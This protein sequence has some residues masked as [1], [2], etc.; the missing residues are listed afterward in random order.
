[1]PQSTWSTDVPQAFRRRYGRTEEEFHQMKKTLPPKKIV[2]AAKAPAPLAKKPAP[3][4]APAPLA[5]KPA[6]APAPVAKKPAPAPAPLAKKAA[7][8]PAPLA[9]KPAPAPAPL[10]K[11]AAPAPAPLAK[12]VAPAPAPLAKKAAPAPVA[13]KGAPAPLAKKVVAKAPVAA[14]KKG[15]PAK[16]SSGPSIRLGKPQSA[17]K[18]IVSG[19]R[20]T[21]EAFNRLFHE[22]LMAMYKSVEAAQIAKGEDPDISPTLQQSG[23]IVKLVE[24]VWAAAT[25][26]SSIAWAGLMVKRKYI[27]P[28]VFSSPIMKE[29]HSFVPGHYRIKV[30]HPCYPTA[31]KEATQKGVNDSPEEGWFTPAEWD[32]DGNCAATDEP[33]NVA[34]IIS[35]EKAKAKADAKA[36][37]KA[38]KVAKAT[39]AAATADDEEEAAAEEEDEV[40]EEVAEDEEATEEAGE[41]EA[42]E[43][44][45]EEAAEEEEEAAEDEEEAAEEEEEEA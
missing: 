37:A 42:T 19:G 9:K 32:E 4:P 27:L 23:E 33:F 34:E 29:Q 45:E 6:P 10:A 5:K 38:A 24:Q 7:P 17:V 44:G 2:P 36:A 3:A 20:T 18:D 22:K 26:E 30:D 8:A 16:K 1:M 13:K 28:R 15:A 40:T 43:E 21:R 41:E 25:A 12:K 11:K 31:L 14:A 35:D 39:K